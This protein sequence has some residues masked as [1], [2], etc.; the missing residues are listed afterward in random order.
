M[1]GRGRHGTF[2]PTEAEQALLRAHGDALVLAGQID[3]GFALHAAVRCYRDAAECYAA[4]V[5][6]LT[7]AAHVVTAG[8]LAQQ[9]LGMSAEKWMEKAIACGS[10]GTSP[11]APAG[12]ELEGAE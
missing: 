10:S 12:S 4:D 9:A 11:S 3:A 8:A 7:W 2:E 5:L 6:G 1:V